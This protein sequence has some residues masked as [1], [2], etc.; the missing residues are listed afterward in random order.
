MICTKD[1][2]KDPK[3][4]QEYEALEEEFSLVAAQIEARTRGGS[5]Q[6]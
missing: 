5:T 6:E 2:M 1:W 3:Y 4:R